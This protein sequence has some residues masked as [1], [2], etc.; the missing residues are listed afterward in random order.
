MPITSIRLDNFKSYG[1]QTTIPLPYAFT[2]VRGPPPPP[3]AAADAA[4]VVGPNGAGKSNLMDAVS[5]VLGVQARALRGASLAV[6][7]PP[8]P[9]GRR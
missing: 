5:F 1:G 6:R 2:A 4:Q 9:F 7:P 3:S 8:S